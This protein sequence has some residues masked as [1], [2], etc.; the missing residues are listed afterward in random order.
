MYFRRLGEESDGEYSRDSSS[1]GSS[2][3]E[4]ERSGSN[5]CREPSNY[6]E[7][8]DIPLAVDQL[9]GREHQMAFQEGFSSDEGE[10]G[11]SQGCLLFE[12]LERDPPYSREPLANKVGP[13]SIF[14]STIFCF[15]DNLLRENATIL[16]LQISDLA[17]HCPELKTLRSCDL[18]PSSWISVAWYS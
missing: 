12:Y 6:L 14:H 2:D 5:Y 10:T 8:N 16:C 13:F 15:G 4:H 3:G 18:L 17:L 1:D 11:N 7:R 9:A